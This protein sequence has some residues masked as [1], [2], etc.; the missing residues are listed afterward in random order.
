MND[1]GIPDSVDAR[2][3]VARKAGK[4]LVRDGVD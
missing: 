1:D 3:S 4:D 2:V